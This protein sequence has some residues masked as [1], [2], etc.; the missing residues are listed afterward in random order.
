ML[1]AQSVYVQEMKFNDQRITFIQT[2]LRVKYL[3]IFFLFAI[4]KI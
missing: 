4:V 2:F 1:K 3:K